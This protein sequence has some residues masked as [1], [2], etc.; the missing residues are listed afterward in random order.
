MKSALMV[1]AAVACLAVAGV[2]A[3]QAGAAPTVTAAASAKVDNFQL[4]DHKLMAYELY[5]Y[6]YMPA[7][8]V[9]SHTNGSAYSQAAAAELEK[10]NAAYKA[11]RAGVEVEE[12]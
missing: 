9:M 11:E 5:Y 8:V 12:V 4:T 1:A 7:I 10:L 3:V 6:K 2:A